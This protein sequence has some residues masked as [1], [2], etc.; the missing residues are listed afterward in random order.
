[1]KR[2]PKPPQQPAKPLTLRR[3]TIRVLD[4]DALE[5]SRGGAGARSS[6]FQLNQ[7]MDQA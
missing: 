1:M 4:D 7:M 2:E 3:E 5:Q 6:K